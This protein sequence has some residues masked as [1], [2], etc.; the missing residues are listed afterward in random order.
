MF[1][2]SLDVFT[3]T[4][5]D[6]VCKH[7][8]F[9]VKVNELKNC[10]ISL[11]EVNA[12]TCMSFYIARPEK[13]KQPSTFQAFVFFCLLNLSLIYFEKGTKEQTFN[14]DNFIWM[15][16]FKSLPQNTSGQSSFFPVLVCGQWHR[17]FFSK[18][19]LT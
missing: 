16:W 11:Q 14:T 10:M 17:Y 18:L 9:L 19:N 6:I 4:V 15:T 12:K 3:V 2:L 1:F 8:D 7:D 13:G 5:N